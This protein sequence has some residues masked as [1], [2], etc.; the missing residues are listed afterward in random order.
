MFEYYFYKE[1]ECFIRESKHRET[2]ES[3]R[4]FFEVFE[5]HNETRTRVVEITSRC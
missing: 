1:I 5:Y 3:A 4:A 2:I